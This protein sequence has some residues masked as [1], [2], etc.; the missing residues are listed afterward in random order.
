MNFS[1]LFACLMPFLHLI[2]YPDCVQSLEKLDSNN[3]LLYDRTELL[4]ALTVG[5]HAVDLVIMAKL[6]GGSSSN[7][8][9]VFVAWMAFLCF[10]LD[11]VNLKP[12]REFIEAFLP[13]V[14]VDAGYADCGCNVFRRCREY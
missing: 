1:C 2:V 14:F 8:S 13:R 10:V 3:R 5:R 12:L 7:I 11:E 9:R 4:V 6:V